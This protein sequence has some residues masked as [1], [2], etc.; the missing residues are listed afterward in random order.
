MISAVL[1]EQLQAIDTP[2]ICNALE[3]VAPERPLRRL[4]PSGARLPVPDHE[5]RWLCADSRR[6]V[7]RKPRAGCP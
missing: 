7:A 6:P 1:L 5:G 4:Q 3:I 2:T